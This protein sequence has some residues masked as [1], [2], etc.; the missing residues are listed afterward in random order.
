MGISN[1]N[2]L[3]RMWNNLIDHLSTLGKIMAWCI[4][5]INHYWHQ[6]WPNYKIPIDNKSAIFRAKN[7]CQDINSL[8]PSDAVWRHRHYIDVTKTTV[9]SQI[10]SLTVVYST[11]YS[12]ADQ[13][14]HQSSASLAFVW[15]IHR[16][17]SI[18]RTKGQLRG[19]CF[20]LMTSSWSGLKLAHVIACC[21]TAPSQ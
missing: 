18:P 12:D 21:L 4:H 6:Y 1:E 2:V 3:K 15:G 7:S 19:K 5:G 13:R 11:V 8:W 9:A 14:T 20:H 16:D 10:T 17:R